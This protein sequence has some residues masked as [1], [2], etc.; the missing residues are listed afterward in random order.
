MWWQAEFPQDDGIAYLNHA[1]VSP[2]PACTVTRSPSSPPR[3]SARVRPPTRDGWK[4]N[5]D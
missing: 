4:R 3:T 5:I 2:W 1:G